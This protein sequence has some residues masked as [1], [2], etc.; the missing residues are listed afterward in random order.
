MQD[1]MYYYEKFLNV[2]SYNAILNFIIGERGVGKTYGATKYVTNKFIKTGDEF[3]YLRRYK[4]ELKTSVP[5]FF[6]ALI[7]NNEFKGHDLKSKENKFYCDGKICG[8]AIPLSTANILK[9]TSFTKVKTI[10]FDEFII[11]KGTYHYLSNEVIQ[12]LD[13]IE[14]IA[15][16]RDIRVLFLGNAISIT[17]PYFAYF[18]LTLPYNSDIKTFKDGLI[19][20]NYIKNEKYREVKKQTRF[21]K[22]IEGTSYSKYAIDNEFLRDSKAFIKKKT[23]QAKFFFILYLDGNTYGVWRDLKEDVFYISTQIDSLCPIRFTF[24][25]DEH[26]SNTILASRRNN[27]WVKSIIEHYRLARLCFE[28]QKIKNV[29]M[30]YISRLLTY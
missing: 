17:N 26:N 8:Y 3:V 1:T 11:D 10:I 18:D 13:I 25:S 15:R 21:G 12:L 6:D 7:N 20:V 23:P 9:S 2:L 4:T 27:P 16:L 30:E 22:L 24:N 5:K 14:T 28:N 19:L 29:L